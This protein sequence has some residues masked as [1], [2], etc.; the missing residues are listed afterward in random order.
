MKAL[1]VQ[2]PAL[3]D[4]VADVLERAGHDVTRCGPSPNRRF[5]C[6]GVDGGCPLDG[7]VDVAVAVHSRSPG[8]LGLGEAGVVCAL[9]DGIPVVVAG[10]A[11]GCA[12]REHVA[13]VAAGLD[14]V[15]AACGRALDARDRQL[16]RLVGGRVERRGDE[17]R[18]ILPPGTEPAAAVRAHRTLADALPKARTIDVRI[19]RPDAEGPEEER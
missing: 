10:D 19:A 14:D 2:D 5:P 12:Y 6:R 3:G 15:A 9:R 4:V 11:A 13:A 18:A 16:G 7:S 1:L 17:V 8:D